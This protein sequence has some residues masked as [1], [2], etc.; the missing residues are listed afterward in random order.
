[1]S[2]P[3]IDLPKLAG[4]AGS[5]VGLIIATAIFLS[6]VTAAF[7][8]AGQRS[9]G[10]EAALAVVSVIGVA[11][12]AGALTL[13]VVTVLFAIRDN[14]IDRRSIQAE[15]IDLDEVNGSADAPRPA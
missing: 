5:A 7:P 1:M 15:A 11:A 2:L 10:E 3:E 14:R 13:D 12:V 8:P 9:G 4:V 6:W